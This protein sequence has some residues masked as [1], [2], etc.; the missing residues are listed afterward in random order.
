VFHKLR[1][2]TGLEPERDISRCSSNLAEVLGFLPRSNLRGKP[3][4]VYLAM[5]QGA[6]C[7]YHSLLPS[8]AASVYPTALLLLESQLCS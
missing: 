7:L 2:V 8:G 4:V 5:I 1:Q 6:C 3:L